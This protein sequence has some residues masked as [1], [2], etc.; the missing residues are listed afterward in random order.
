MTA[1]PT[2]RG[3]EQKGTKT[4]TKYTA[5]LPKEIQ[6]VI[7]KMR[8]RCTRIGTEETGFWCGYMPCQHPQAATAGCGG[9]RV[10][11]RVFDGCLSIGWAIAAHDEWETYTE[12]GVINNFGAWHDADSIVFKDP[13]LAAIL[14]E[15]LLT[16]DDTK[17]RIIAHCHRRNILRQAIAEGWFPDA[18][19]GKW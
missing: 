9:D 6:A 12:L 15:A 14:L 13:A 3:G 18:L 11:A 19:E 8:G 16:G 7:D 17:R 10:F 4:V 1:L 2:L 5:P